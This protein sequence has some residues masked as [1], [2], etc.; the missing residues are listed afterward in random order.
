[1]SQN[2]I[3]ILIAALVFGAIGKY[4]VDAVTDDLRLRR[5]SSRRSGGDMIM[6]AIMLNNKFSIDKVLIL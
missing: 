4:T 5:R 2:I 1:M 3:K 6:S